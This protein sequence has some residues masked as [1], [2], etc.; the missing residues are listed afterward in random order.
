MMKNPLA[1]K[2]ESRKEARTYFK[3]SKRK[4]KMLTR[5]EE[6]DLVVRAKAGD[7][8]ARNELFVAHHGSIIS[9]ARLF[10]KCRLSQE[11]IIQEGYLGL[12]AA[13]ENINPDSGFR[14][15]TYAKHYVYK[16]MRIAVHDQVGTVTIPAWA[17]ELN[18][19]VKAIRA[20]PGCEDLSDEDV[21]KRLGVWQFPGRVKTVAMADAETV[22][23]RDSSR[24]SQFEDGRSCSDA[25]PIDPG[26]SAEYRAEMADAAAAVRRRMGRLSKLQQY[27]VSRYFGLDGNSPQTTT[28]IAADLGRTRSSVYRSIDRAKAYLAKAVQ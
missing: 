6:F 17:W 20:K 1:N 14:F 25:D 10:S 23:L 18:C 15:W 21:A 13:M 22:P 24:R 5:A 9:S 3:C 7:L 26:P 2:C 27:C 11:D 4:Y 16:F 19:K 8:E 12:I 28:E